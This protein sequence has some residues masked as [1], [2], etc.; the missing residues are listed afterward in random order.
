MRN[1]LKALDDITDRDRTLVGGKAFHCARL[2]QS[3]FPVPDGVVVP[4]HAAEEDVRSLA[5]HRWFGAQ[6]GDVRYA[7]RSSGADEDG[8]HDSFAGIHETRLNVSRG[9]LA[10][11]VLACRRSADS[12]QAVAYRHERHLNRA[13]TIAVL[14]QPMVPAVASGVAFTVNP[15]TGADELIINAACGLGEALVSGQVDPDEF[16]VRKNDRTLTSSRLGNGNATAALSSSQIN[17]LAGILLR[18]EQHYGAPQD[19]EFCHDGRQFWIVQS[20]PVTT[21]PAPGTST[22]HPARGT[23]TQHPALST[24]HPVDR[25]PAVEWTRANLAEVLPEQMSPQALYSFERMLNVAQRRFMGKLLAPEA[26][27]GPVFKVFY[28]RMYMNLSQMRRVCRLIGSPAADM[29]RSLG[30][31]AQIQPDD[32]IAAPRPLKELLP[33]LPDF[34]RIGWMDVRAA[35]LFAAHERDTQATVD[36]LAGTRPESL[37]DAELWKMFEWWLTIVPDA[38]QMVFVMSGVLLRESQIKRACQQVG[39]PYEQLVY[40][41]L[42]AGE[43]SVSTQQAFALVRL[44]ATARREVKVMRYLLDND[45]TFADVETMLAGTDFLTEFTRFLDVYGHRGHYESDW[46]LPRLYEQPAPALFAIREQLKGEPQDVEALAMRQEAAAAHAWREFEDRLTRWQRLTLLPLVRALLR[47]LK[48]Q[49]VWREK[50]RSNLTRV[51]RYCRE[52]H[53]VMAQRFAERGW[54]ARR[55]DYFLLM[56]EEVGAVVADPAKASALKQIVDARL[57]QRA[58][59]RDLQLPLYA[60]EA[61]LP[62]L[63]HQTLT[64]SASSGVLTGLCVS[65]GTVEAE[66]VVLRDPGEFAAMKRGAILVTRATDPSW[67]P[68]FTLASGVVVEVGGMLS[69]ASTI[70][71]EYGLPALANVSNATTVLSTGQRVRLDASAGRLTVL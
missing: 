58:A 12:E 68:L 28:G 33:L 42:A 61:D 49:Y 6:P 14:V 34:L 51:L 45:G 50:V 64:P 38:M 4:A 48:Q 17:E 52:Y 54:L 7:V 20:R 36:R 66:V 43:R 37:S 18:I 55:D 24:Q 63:I 16:I 31:P 60:R 46:A 2:R 59:E 62:R 29:L 5:S 27:L 1:R 10:D 23:S 13:G 41:Q 15:V 21:H 11:A 35:T 26:E 39:Y 22:Q 8:V 32:E 70:A 40:P 71:R 69:H 9:D 19:V 25:H 30:H 47:R 57:V 53:L 65:H 3:G 67:T 44:A 56:I